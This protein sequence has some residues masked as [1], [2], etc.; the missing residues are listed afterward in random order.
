M[1]PEN[2]E[3]TDEEIDNFFN[4]LEQETGIDAKVAKT[5]IM[6][7]FIQDLNQ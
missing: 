5:F 3:Y 1:I 4:Y 6:N 7:E 2:P